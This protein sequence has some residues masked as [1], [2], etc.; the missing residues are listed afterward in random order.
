MLELSYNLQILTSP[1]SL[2]S[3]SSCT[4]DTGKLHTQPGHNIHICTWR[5]S[6]ASTAGLVEGLEWWAQ[7]EVV[8]SRAGGGWEN[9]RRHFLEGKSRGGK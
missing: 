1:T 7:G 9:D 4:M 8:A 5:R 2:S 3:C 6:F